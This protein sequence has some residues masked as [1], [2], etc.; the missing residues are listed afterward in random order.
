METKI[1][2]KCIYCENNE[3]LTEKQRNDLKE[4]HKNCEKCGNKMIIVKTNI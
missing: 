4:D 3:I 1:I 2:A